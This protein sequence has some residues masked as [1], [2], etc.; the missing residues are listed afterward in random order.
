[1]VSKLNPLYNKNP[2]D[3]V[4]VYRGALVSVQAFQNEGLNGFPSRGPIGLQGFR[5]DGCRGSG[6]RVCEGLGCARVWALEFWI[7]ALR[8]E[9][10][11]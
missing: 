6:F 2:V 5:V 7:Q 1:M 4:G 11:V 8:F 3:P 10:L 9:V